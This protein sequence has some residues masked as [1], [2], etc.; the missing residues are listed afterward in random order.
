MFFYLEYLLPANLKALYQKHRSAFDAALKCPPTQTA[1]LWQSAIPDLLKPYLALKWGAE[2]PEGGLQCWL[3]AP[4]PYQKPLEAAMQQTAERWQHNAPL[5]APYILARL[6]AGHPLSPELAAVTVQL[7][8]FNLESNLFWE[9]Q[10]KTGTELKELLNQ[11]VI[12]ERSPGHRATISTV[13]AKLGWGNFTLE[14]GDSDLSEQVR[15]LQ[16]LWME[17]RHPD[18]AAKLFAIGA[19]QPPP[20]ALKKP[21]EREAWVRQAL[22]TADPAIVS[23]VFAMPWPARWQDAASRIKMLAAFPPD[24]R[25]AKAML[26]FLKNPPYAAPGLG[27]SC[28]QA[29]QLLVNSQD[30]A[31]RS[32]AMALT[33]PFRNRVTF[34][35][36]PLNWREA[37]KKGRGVMPLSVEQAQGLD[38]L[39]IPA[40]QTR[41]IESLK[42]EILKNPDAMEPRLVLGDLLV[43]AGD[44]YGEFIQLQCARAMGG[45]TPQSLRKEKALWNTHRALWTREPVGLVP[46][47]AVFERGFYAEATV[48]AGVDPVPVLSHPLASTLHTLTVPGAASAEACVTLLKL[49]TLSNLKRF[50]RPL[51]IRDPIP[52]VFYRLESIEVSNYSDRNVLVAMKHLKVLG[53]HNEEL[54]PCARGLQLEEL[55]ILYSRGFLRRLPKGFKR[56]VMVVGELFRPLGTWTFTGDSYERLEISYSVAGTHRLGWQ[57]QYLGGMP[58]GLKEIRVKKLPEEARQVLEEFLK[59]VDERGVVVW[60]R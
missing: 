47:E 43:E 37:L 41:S 49:P 11:S 29:M 54:L 59:D 19:C 7:L 50:Y 38:D 16:K 23:A 53:L 18:V 60:D 24:P 12:S 25:I 21:T 9:I 42:E 36:R 57:L 45:G 2:K 40:G 15:W 14:S 6:D 51:D 48:K 28:L 13:L 1:L 26:D 55:R 52:E 32:E 34:N 39:K 3:S 44:P 30:P 46:D 35:D 10:K 4:E 58:D 31:T 8:K 5:F 17:T 56:L 22:Q 33:V 20:P 27:R